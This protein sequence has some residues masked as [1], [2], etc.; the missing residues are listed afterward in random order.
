[1]HYYGYDDQE[2]ALQRERVVHCLRCNKR[3]VADGRLCEPCLE[4]LAVFETSPSGLQEE[5]GNED[6]SGDFAEHIHNAYFDEEDIPPP[7]AED[8]DDYEIA[9]QRERAARAAVLR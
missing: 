4:S 8:N 3:E 1:M 2:R 9:L 5:L 6:M 7:Q